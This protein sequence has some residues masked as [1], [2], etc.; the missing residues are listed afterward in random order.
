MKPTRTAT[1]DEKTIDAIFASVDQSQLPG[2]AVAVAIDGVPV[3]RKGFG[4]ASMELPVQLAPSMRMRIGSTTKHFAALAFLLLCEEGKAGFDDTIGTYL[5]DI[6]PASRGATMRQLMSHTSGIR[7]AMALA[8]TLDG[9]A[10]HSTDRDMLAYY[11]AIEDVDFAPETSWSYNNG[12]YVLL[13]AA[14]ERVTSQP[15]EAVLRER[16]FEPVGMA[17]TLLRRT[18]RNFV[19][20]SATL[21]FRTP[22]GHF[23][24]DYMGAEISGAGGVVST[25]DDMLRWLAHMDA[26]HVGSAET[27]Q[28][29]RTPVTLANGTRTAYGFG[30]VNEAYRGVDTI[31]HG[32]GVVAGN[33]Q[34]IKVPAAGLDISIAVNRAD[35]SAA[36]FACAIIDACVE[37]LDPLPDG[38]APEPVSGLFL[39]R[40][41]G[42]VLELAGHD[43]MQLMGLD[44]APMLPLRATGTK[45]QALPAIMA[46]ILQTFEI[47]PDEVLL[48]DFGNAIAFA[49]ASPEPDAVLGP[50]AGTYRAAL[51][52]TLE[53]GERDGEPRMIAHGLSG[54]VAYRLMPLT[55][56]IW[57]A[58]ID[59]PFAMFGA[60]VT[61]Q[62][63]ARGLS[64]T[65]GRMKNLHFARA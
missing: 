27:W 19:P 60:I 36:Q 44:A 37:G 34:M 55:G 22:D 25:M 28:A 52:A 41:T 24:R 51:G 15:L 8:M 20:N 10:H 49:P 57:K 4:L 56:T 48:N 12:G 61:F 16:I 54:S 11:A 18:D 23:T 13:T 30:L 38:V 50:L 2:A 33:S 6:H 39:S 35:V 53:F 65:V 58:N 64:L 62:P 59:G 7:D 21:H 1:L 32:G 5:P 31:S 17:D 47:A 40:D 26:P 9:P 42:Q 29:M 46:F 14:I 3:Y 63:D 45:A 43:G